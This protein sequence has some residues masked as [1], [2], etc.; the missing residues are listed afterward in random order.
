MIYTRFG[1]TITLHSKRQEG[2]GRL[3][4]QATSRDPGEVREYDVGDLE[5]DGG[6]T[7]IDEA[8]ARLPWES[9]QQRAAR[10]REV[11]GEATHGRGQTW[12]EESVADEGR[13]GKNAVSATDGK[14]SRRHRRRHADGNTRRTAQSVG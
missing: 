7:E 9:V 6:F 11:R 5:A 1:S 10:A 4:I 13:R 12:A 14:P 3:S 8:V 2:N